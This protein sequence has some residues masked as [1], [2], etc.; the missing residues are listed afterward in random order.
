MKN[1][2]FNLPI[3]STVSVHEE[4]SDPIR[5]YVTKN[6]ITLNGTT[7]FPVGHIID[8]SSI[9]K[10]N[11]EL[12]LVTVYC[13][14]QEAPR[15]HISRSDLYQKTV[16]RV[17]KSESYF[18]EKENVGYSKK[19]ADKWNRDRLQ[20]DIQSAVH[21]HGPVRIWFFS[22]RRHDRKQ[23]FTPTTT[24]ELT[25]FHVKVFYR[26]T[27]TKMRC[28]EWFKGFNTYQLANILKRMKKNIQRGISRQQ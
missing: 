3:A 24:I 10:E 21:F 20:L 17:T 15:L 14:L 27:E 12:N 19:L 2:E 6:P 7:V 16:V 23:P 22:C 13:H 8:P 18:L 28:D 9:I 5:V 4:R 26:G 1:P 11:F 25:E